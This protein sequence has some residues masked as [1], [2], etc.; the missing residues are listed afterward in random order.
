MSL[1]IRSIDT[2]KSKARRRSKIEQSVRRAFPQNGKITSF[3]GKIAVTKGAND[4]WQREH[5]NL[6]ANF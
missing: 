2:H 4:A 6:E 5:E 1:L 3:N